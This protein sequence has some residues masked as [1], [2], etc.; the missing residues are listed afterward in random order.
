MT[1]LYNLEEVDAQLAR[2]QT[3]GARL[4]YLDL[5]RHRLARLERRAALAA[6]RDADEPIPDAFSFA[7]L[8]NELAL[9][10]SQ[11]EDGR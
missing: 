9:R 2:L 4:V 6:L 1:P 8:D 7:I 10:A 3:R 11:V 5:L